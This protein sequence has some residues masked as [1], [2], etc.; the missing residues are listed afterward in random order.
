MFVP[1]PKYETISNWKENFKSKGLF[2]KSP[3]ITFTESILKEGK[4]KESPGPGAYHIPKSIFHVKKQDK[5][6]IAKTEKVCEFIEEAKFR[7]T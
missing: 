5:G 1:G 2:S 4:A 6:L 7:G 3:R